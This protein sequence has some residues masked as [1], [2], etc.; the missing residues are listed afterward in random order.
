MVAAMPP[1]SHLHRS[2]SAVTRFIRSEE[3]ETLLERW[4]PE[5]ADRRFLVRCLVEEG[6]LHHRGANYV[7]LR[8]MADL[9][10]A[11]GADRDGEP[12]GEGL[13]IPMRLPPHLRKEATED[14]EYPLRLPE[15]AIQRLAPPGSRDFDAIV[16]CLA[17][18]PPQHAVANVLM[19]TLL[20]ELLDRVEGR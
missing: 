3:I 4:V 14:A 9:V 10:R 11:V 12:R 7:V 18:G 13:P 2:Q 17:D 19:V 6:P 16:D 8:L 15:R 5:A 1:P 20:H